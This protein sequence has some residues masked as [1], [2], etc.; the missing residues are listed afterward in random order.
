VSPRAALAVTLAAP[1]LPLG[2]LAFGLAVLWGGVALAWLALA[3]REPRAS[4]AVVA[5]PLLAALGLLALAP[6]AIA[7][8]RGHVRRGVAAAAAVALA[9][10]TAGLRGADLPFG[11]GAPPALDLAGE[12]SAWAAAVALVGAVPPPLAAELV[13]LAAVAVALPWARGPWRIAGLGAAMLA[14]TLLVAPAAPA[15]P[16]VAAAWLTCIALAARDAR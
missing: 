14:A 5:A 3:W 15:L 12:E 13:V 1:I 6:L 11:A 8:L 2:N 9:A 4:L 16:L 7:P 10:V